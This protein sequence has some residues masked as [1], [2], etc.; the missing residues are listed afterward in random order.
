MSEKGEQILLNVFYFLTTAILFVS[1]YLPNSRKP[2][3]QT[4]D[5]L[6]IW[7]CISYK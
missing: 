6:I 1:D 7:F 3:D 2:A 5:N 4:V